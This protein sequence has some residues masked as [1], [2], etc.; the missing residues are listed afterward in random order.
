MVVQYVT[1]NFLAILI[2]TVVA[3]V[4]G[5]SWYSSFLFGNAWMRLSGIDPKKIDKS[6]MKG[7]WKIMIV[8]FISNLIMAFVLS[9]FIKLSQTTSA[10]DATQLGFWIWLGFMMPLQLGMVLWENKPFKLFLI[11]TSH[12]LV[13][14]IVMGLIIALW[15]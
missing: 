13:T 3:M 7:M 14:L 10:T 12:Y 1:V 2:A 9:T 5:M 4:I 8:A 6:K 15:P 11:N